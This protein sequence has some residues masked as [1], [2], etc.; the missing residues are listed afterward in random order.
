M[1]QERAWRQSSLASIALYALVAPLSD[2][3]PLNDHSSLLHYDDLGT[4]GSTL[5]EIDCVLIDHADATGGDTLADSRR[6]YRP[7]D[8]KK[9]VLIVL[10]EIHRAGAER[11]VWT[12]SH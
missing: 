3:N 2:G 4:D 8:A 10:P 1:N 6:L 7:V 9:R 5:I 12:A 11:I